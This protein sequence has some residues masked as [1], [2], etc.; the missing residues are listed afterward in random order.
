MKKIF[1]LLVG[2]ICSIVCI[3]ATELTNHSSN[4]GC[5]EML[6]TGPIYWEG[7]V[8]KNDGRYN[9]PSKIKIKVYRSDNMCDSFVAHVYV[10]EYSEWLYKAECIVKTSQRNNYGFYITY[11]GSDYFFNM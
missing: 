1:L 2:V 7:I 6:T 3:R 9:S 4:S 10:L 8:E 11:E 5:V